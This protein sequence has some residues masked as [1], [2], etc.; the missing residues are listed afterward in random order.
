MK[1]ILLSGGSGKRLWPLSNN[2]RSKQFIKA[3]KNEEGKLDSMVQRVW[4]QLGQAG[5]Q[6]DTFIATGAGQKSL[7]KNQLGIDDKKIIVE[8]SRRDTF[9]AI[10]LAATYLHSMVDV[11]LNE[12]MIVFPVDP[13]VG[14]EFFNKI[15]ELDLLL[16]NT[17][18]TLGLVGIAPTMP[19]E[20]YGYIVPE[21]AESSK[22]QQF[23]EKPSK[24]VAEK[25]I[26]QGAVWNAGVFGLK[27][28]TLI[29]LLKASKYDTDYHGLVQNYEQL[30]KTS[31]DYEF[32][33]KQDNIS[34]LRYDGFWKDLGTWNTLTEEVLDKNIGHASIQIDTKNTNIINETTLPI[35]AIGVDNLVIAA[36][37]E[38][39]FV[40]T[41]EAS[42][43]V[44]EIPEQFFETIHYVEENWGIR[45]T[46]YHTEKA[47]AASYEVND[48]QTLKITLE[49]RQNLLRLSGEGIFTYK[50][51]QVEITGLDSL[52]FVVVT[53]EDIV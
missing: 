22:V 38:G 6:G 42:P 43:R 15:K 51:K 14:I 13:F 34:F 33:E 24:A 41:K 2:Q 27:V 48:Q 4:K 39:I 10:A 16:K 20:K 53:E 25:L 45:R 29:N 9:P 52:V 8:P 5:L 17:N 31:F 46:L 19:S 35:A 30:P 23:Q 47:H 37:P 28:G 7:L 49:R 40:S 12:T 11:S 1:L 32:S 18:S 26:D 21:S 50:G 44:K 36:G 3:L